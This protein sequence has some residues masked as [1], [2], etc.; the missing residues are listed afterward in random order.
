MNV[1]ALKGM[2]VL[3]QLLAPFPV[4]QES[5]SRGGGVIKGMRVITSRLFLLT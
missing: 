1:S 2:L 3:S 5:V 4:T